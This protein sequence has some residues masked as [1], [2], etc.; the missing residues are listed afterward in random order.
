MTTRQFRPL[1][2]PL[3]ELGR[4]QIVTRHKMTAE[5]IL[6][7]R[8]CCCCWSIARLDD[9]HS[10]TAERAR[11][12]LDIYNWHT[13]DSDGNRRRSKLVLAAS[14]TEKK[15]VDILLGLVFFCGRSSCVRYVSRGRR[16]LLCIPEAVVW[17]IS[18][19]ALGA[20]MALYPQRSA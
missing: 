2:N 8:D 20:G 4:C 3:D 5:L 19:C 12:H 1:Q 14:T 10:S 15:L 7:N 9:P 18:G 13:A 6:R 16:L 17:S 11:N